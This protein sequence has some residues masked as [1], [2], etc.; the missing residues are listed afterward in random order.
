MAI[1]GNN[2]KISNEKTSR[3]RYNRKLQTNV[4]E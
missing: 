1:D 4:I 3:K 2:F